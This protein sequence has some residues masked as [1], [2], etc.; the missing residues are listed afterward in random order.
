LEYI[1]K[2]GDGPTFDGAYELNNLTAL[3]P[4]FGDDEMPIV[5]LYVV[6][7]AQIDDAMNYL[8]DQGA[9]S[10]YQIYDT[11]EPDGPSLSQ[12]QSFNSGNPPGADN[13]SFILHGYRH[14]YVSRVLNFSD[15]YIGLASMFVCD[16]YCN[17]PDYRNLC[18]V[19]LNARKWL[20][21]S[22]PNYPVPSFYAF[23][24]DSDTEWMRSTLLK[25]QICYQAALDQTANAT[26]GA[27][28]NPA[29]YDSQNGGCPWNWSN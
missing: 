5:G 23:E 16:G 17:P 27:A 7:Y 14:V 9:A 20:L 21:T 4:C 12:V 8:L 10:L 18:D 28:I 24:Q 22:A 25:R 2:Y 19:Y 29:W 11:Y 15:G 13:V 3:E 1:A 26:M 6:G